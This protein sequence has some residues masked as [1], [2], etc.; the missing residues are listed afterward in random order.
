MVPA[1]STLTSLRRALDEATKKTRWTWGLVGLFIVA[2]LVLRLIMFRESAWGDELSTLWII[3][4]NDFFGVVTAV[5]S[6]AEISP[7]FYFLLAKVSSWIFGQT[8][9]GVR[10]PSL[11]AGVLTVPAFY[12][13][14]L[15]ALG[16]RAALYATA[17]ATVAPFLVYF[18][19]NA[20]AYSVM[21]LMLLVATWCLLSATS[22]KG[23]LWHWI[24]WSVF[25]CLAV[26]SHYTACLAVAGQL[27]WA[28]WLFPA[29]RL[30]ALAFAGLMLLLFLPWLGGF[31]ND[32]DSPT[33]DIL[34]AIQGSGFEV[35]WAAVKD[36]FFLWISAS[37]PSFFERP[38]MLLA[39]AGVLVA[40]G[41]MVAA[42]V[43]GSLPKPSPDRLKGV[44]LAFLMV[45]TVFA[46]ELLLLAAGTDIFGARNLAPVWAALPLL[47]AAGAAAAGPRWGLVAVVLI[48][49]GFSVTT[50]RLLDPAR[51]TIPYE[52]ASGTIEST[53]EAGGSIV[54][55]SIISPA[56]LSPLD[57]YLDLDLREFRMTNLEDR[58]DFIEDIYRQYD[59]QKIA[60]QAFDTAGPVRVVTIGDGR[61][62]VPD[63]QGGHVFKV[64]FA[65]VRIPPGWREQGRV[66]HEGLEPLTVTV[67]QRE[68]GQ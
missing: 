61:A 5:N 25:G 29:L 50:A 42:R 47:I 55:A 59:P 45:S 26:Y 63:G 28:L 23:R 67:F 37:K 17:I 62:P 8:P 10:L 3:R 51:S 33:S 11:I 14:G 7:P 13:V 27:I 48:A 36:L 57:G 43:R 41:A 65:E 44:W 49:A 2:G 22:D 68:G 66:R 19:A 20:R 52:K 58:P 30:K 46:A 16:R 31:R 15:K 6:D 40:T 60:D 38:D 9:D 1:A 54:D 64:G 4:G 21:I 18:S 35:K 53:S 34:Q 32:L 12:L 56:P 24:G 39:L